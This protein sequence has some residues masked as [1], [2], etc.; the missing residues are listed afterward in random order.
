MTLINGSEGEKKL[1]LEKTARALK[2]KSD[3]NED[4]VIL[5]APPVVNTTKP[6]YQK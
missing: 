4:V 2:V 1:A 6:R 5:P 3:E